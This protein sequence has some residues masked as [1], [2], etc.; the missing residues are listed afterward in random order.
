MNKNAWQNRPEGYKIVS[1]HDIEKQQQ[2]QQFMV[3]HAEM[4]LL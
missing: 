2:Q 1:Q 4:T 3:R